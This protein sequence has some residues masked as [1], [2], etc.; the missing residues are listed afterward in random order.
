MAPIAAVSGSRIAVAPSWTDTAAMSPTAA[1]LTPVEQ[2]RGHRP[3]PDP[4]DPW[5]DERDDHERGQEDGHRGDDGAGHTGD[6]VADEGRGGEQR[7]RRDLADRDGV[8]E[9]RIGKPAQAFDEVA[10]KKVIS[11]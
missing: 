2:R 7:S 11:T 3:I 4:S 9:L 10:R 8:D 5:P 6:H 1:A